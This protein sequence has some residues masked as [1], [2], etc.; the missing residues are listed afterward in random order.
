MGLIASQMRPGVRV[1][2]H[3]NSGVHSGKYGVIVPLSEVPTDGRGVPTL[4]GH[5]RPLDRKWERAV[6]LDDG[7]LI[8]MYLNRLLNVRSADSD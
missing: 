3:P 1:K 8:T 6:R 5:Y 2:V 4:P 7:E